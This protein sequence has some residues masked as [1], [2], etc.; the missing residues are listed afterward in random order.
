MIAGR[1]GTVALDLM[2]RVL[3]TLAVALVAMVVLVVMAAVALVL[4]FDPNAYKDRITSLASA[5]IGR[6]LHIEGDLKLTLFPW[7]GVRVGSV[8]LANAPG[9]GAEPFARVTGLQV[10]VKVLPLL[11]RRIAMD[12]VASGSSDWFSRSTN[13]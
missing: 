9:F 3:K 1:R 11:Q 10:R 6:E 8:E 5:K 4:F 2:K 7:L 13:I 12:T